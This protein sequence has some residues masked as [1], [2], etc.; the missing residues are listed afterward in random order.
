MI[1][2]LFKQFLLIYFLAVLVLFGHAGFSLVSGKGG[3]SSGSVEPS[4]CGGFSCCGAQT[5]SRAC[6]LEWL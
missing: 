1:C 5:G 4:H 2:T 6:G 3:Y